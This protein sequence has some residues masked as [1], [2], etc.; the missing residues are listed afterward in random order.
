MRS[1]SAVALQ[2]GDCAGDEETDIVVAVAEE[3]VR[4]VLRAG[5]LAGEAGVELDQAGDL[6]VVPQQP[7]ETAGDMG[8]V[9]AG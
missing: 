3:G 7:D 4:P 5:G 8:G 9:A 6:G 1:W 2:L